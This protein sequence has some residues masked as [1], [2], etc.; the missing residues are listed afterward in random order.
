MP[1]TAEDKYD[2]LEK[3]GHGSFGIIR[4]VKRKDDGY[5]MCRKE[6]SYSKM[7]PKEKEQLQSELNILKDLVHPNIVRYYE[8]EHLKASQDLHLYMEYC[9]NGDLSR[10]IQGY[11]NKGR[12]A[13]EEFVWSI[14]S[15][16]VSAL[17]RCHYGQDPPPAGQDVMGL[18]PDA[19][20]VR[21]RSRPMI[22]HRDLKP[23]NIFLDSDNSVKLGDFGLSKILQSHDFASTYVGTPFYMS[24]EIC[25]AE[26]YGP[27]SDIWALGCIIYEMCT[28]QPPFNARTHLELIQKIRAGRYPAI[29]AKYSPDLVKVIAS[30]L[31]VSPSNRPDTAQL[32]NLPIVKLMRK[33]QEVVTISKD[34]KDQ[35][36]RLVEREKAFD[37]KVINMRKDLNDQLRREWEVKAQLEIEKR[38]KFEVERRYQAELKKLQDTFESEVKA[39]VEKALKKYPARPSTSPRLAPRSN[40]PIQPADQGVLFPNEGDTTIIN[41]STSTIGTNGSDW[42]SG[43]DIS[44]L[45]IDD[46]ID[47][48]P[49]QNGPVKVT[50]PL[51]KKKAR[52]PL[53]RAR[54]MAGPATQAPPSP[55][56]VQM[57]EASPASASLAMS[58]LSLSP[59]RE[60]QSSKNIFA[61]AKEAA[62]RWEGEVPPSPTE[63]DWNADLD[64]DD[65][66]AL[67]SPTRSRSGSGGRRSNEDPFKVLA[68]AQKPLSKPTA[69]LVTAPSLAP[70]SRPHSTVPIVATSPSRARSQPSTSS[71]VRRTARPA[72][73]SGMLK[74]KTPAN[75]SRPL[76]RTLVELQQARGIPHTVSE[77]EGKRGMRTGTKS[78][79]KTRSAV[80]TRELKP[81][82]VWN[83]EECDEMPS[84]FIVKTKKLVM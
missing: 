67:P 5:I 75:G 49:V 53:T 60:K 26:Q 35:E 61:A 56:D 30:C 20:P 51:P 64:E 2:V 28:N 62:K 22:L 54:T 70:K 11:K 43:T 71:P 37:V 25:K 1:E 39:Q 52:M 84:P 16:I 79:A 74:K 45:S 81:A 6:I 72:E 58:G 31:Q 77:D 27:H 7:S 19:K 41:G 78:P 48:I 9:G 42:A 69:R 66:P 29:P 4:K 76:G 24:P 83:P 50:N 34:L 82:V 38:V 32:L 46:S 40:T 21:D 23:E 8:R 73:T 15:Q 59:R 65:T 3:I 55:M 33:E 80:N 10:V 17:Y 14:L 12:H 57:G 63:D 68:A 47:D 44:S 18:T 36:K 13:E